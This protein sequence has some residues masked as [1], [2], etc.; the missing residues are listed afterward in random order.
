MD[1]PTLPTN[2][3]DSLDNTDTYVAPNNKAFLADSDVPNTSVLNNAELAQSTAENSSQKIDPNAIIL[4]EALTDKAIS[5]QIHN[6]KIIKKTVTQDLPLPFLYHYDSLDDA[7]KKTHPLTP[8]LL[9]QFNTSMTASQAAKL[10]GIEEAL[11]SRPWHVKVIGSL[12]VFSEA[13][14]LAVRLHWT[15]TGKETQQIYTKNEADAITIAFKDWQFFG[16][17]DVLYKNDKQTLISIDEQSRSTEE[18]LTESLLTIDASSDY[19]QLLNTHALAVIV[20]LEADKA[21][22]PWFDKAI[23]ERIE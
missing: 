4:A 20:R 2:T 5:W 8:T 15:N 21:E 18:P 3:L 11:L 9:T 17:V 1:L 23:L 13:L 22:L 7:V 10:I 14:Q 6:C 16:R 19:Q 12:V